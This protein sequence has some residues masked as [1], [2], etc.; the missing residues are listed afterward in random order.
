MK[1]RYVAKPKPKNI[2][3]NPVITPSIQTVDFKKTASDSQALE[4]KVKKLEK[5]NQT[6][7]QSLDLYHEMM[8]AKSNEILKKAQ[9]LADYKDENEKLQL[10]YQTL[11]HENQNLHTQLAI[12][13]ENLKTNI[14][15]FQR[16][17]QET[18]KMS[19]QL[20]AE[21]NIR[22]HVVDKRF[23]ELQNYYH[24]QTA[25]L[26]E[27]TSFTEEQKKDIHN[28]KR[29]NDEKEKKIQDLTEGAQVLAATCREKEKELELSKKLVESQ[30]KEL[31]EY[32]KWEGDIHK[33][34]NDNDEKQK[35]I[36][37]L[38]EGAQVLAT[39]SC[40]REKE[41]ELSKKL[42]ESQKKELQEYQ[43]WEGDIH[44]LK[45]D[46]DEKQKKIQH[47]T[48]GAKVLAITY[49]KT[50][51]KLASS[52]K[53]VQELI[54]QL[55]EFKQEKEEELQITKKLIEQ[56]K[57]YIDGSKI[58]ISELEKDLIILKENT[59]DYPKKNEALKI[60]NS[61]L[62]RKNK[63]Y[64]EKNTQLGS[65]NKQLK[66]EIAQLRSQIKKLT[67]TE[68]KPQNS[69]EKKLASATPIP[70]M[71]EFNPFHSKENYEIFVK[72]SDLS[73]NEIE[74]LEEEI[75]SQPE[76]ASALV[77][78]LYFSK[79][80][81]SAT[82]VHDAIVYLGPGSS[83]YFYIIALTLYKNWLQEG[84][85]SRVVQTLL[86]AMNPHG[87]TYFMP[88]VAFWLWEWFAKGLYVQKNP[89]EALRYLEMAADQ[90]YPPAVRALRELS[91]MN[92][93]PTASL[94]SNTL[95]QGLKNRNFG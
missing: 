76:K 60:E 24:L 83:L 21:R 25:E 79:E 39:T 81:S 7:H 6:L 8:E 91:L 9:E 18:T 56:Q 75:P 33:L 22:N 84:A 10:D 67:L 2:S 62:I 85:G 71:T 72:R 12:S 77:K 53:Y 32:Q 13:T 51:E 65:E 31:Q 82:N 49:R 68:E 42:V 89:I 38:T 11:E 86:L 95:E 45:N 30:K 14:F 54:G 17:E 16:Q 41:L 78:Q 94:S 80:K 4:E 48:E 73:S 19:L 47:L 26:Q 46:N 66:E 34:K 1:A 43:K 61:N 35:K 52:E 69:E 3:D 28:L 44:K 27:L 23:L 63:E 58:R 87:E 59:D 15:L 50:K 57:K 90:K 55:E 37:D 5:Q 36:Q 92:T 64:K 93:G 74:K 29:D 88:Q 40:E 70:I 20:S